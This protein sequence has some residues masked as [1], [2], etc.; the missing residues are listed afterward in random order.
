MSHTAA[1][2]TR[3]SRPQIEHPSGQCRGGLAKLLTEQSVGLLAVVR[4]GDAALPV[5][6]V[7]GRERRDLVLRRD[8]TGS[9]RAGEGARL[10]AWIDECGI[11]QTVVAVEGEHARCGLA[12]GV[13]REDRGPLRER[14]RDRAQMR[15]LGVAVRAPRGEELEQNRATAVLGETDALALRSLEREAR[16]G[17][18]DGQEPGVRRSGRG[19]RRL[20]LDLTDTRLGRG[21]E[22]DR[23]GRTHERRRRRP[24]GSGR[25]HGSGDLR[26]RARREQHCDDDRDRQRQAAG[27]DPDESPV[28]GAARL[29]PRR[30]RRPR[31]LDPAS[32]RSQPCRLAHPVAWSTMKAV[33]GT[34]F[35]G[36]TLKVRPQ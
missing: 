10:R 17:G 18:T 6:D 3:I 7:E 12:V 15:C 29:L 5:D 28:G 35:F 4:P 2:P 20:P 14:L 11:R 22:A 33:N 31:G 9:A 13:D 27:G 36:V 26:R 30:G 8:G 34:P 1:A 19:R 23:I 24:V 25:R 32:L 16:R 21:V